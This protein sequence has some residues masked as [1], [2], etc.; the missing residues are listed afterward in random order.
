MLDRFNR[1]DHVT[2]VALAAMADL[3]G[4]PSMVAE[5]RYAVAADGR[6]AEFALAVA[7]QWQ[8]RGLATQLMATSALPRQPASRVLRANAWPSTRA[9]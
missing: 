7:D 8:R 1:V 4:T 5:A 6:S 2:Q 9:L 3:D